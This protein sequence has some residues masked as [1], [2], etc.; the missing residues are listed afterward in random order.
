M[1]HWQVRI[2][3]GPSGQPYFSGPP[4]EKG[5]MSRLIR[6]LILSMCRFP[7]GT[8]TRKSRAVAQ[9]RTSYNMML[10]SIFERKSRPSMH[11]PLPIP[12]SRRLASA[13]LEPPKKPVLLLTRETYRPRLNKIV[14]S[15]FLLDW[16]RQRGRREM[17]SPRLNHSVPISNWSFTIRPFHGRWERGRISREA[18][19]LLVH[20]RLTDTRNFSD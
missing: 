5:D 17:D 11:T 16:G 9:H 7:R 18:D 12:N 2:R 3:Y 15:I 4:P 10:H 13:T 1:A 20:H 8:V 19:G 6:C 14:I